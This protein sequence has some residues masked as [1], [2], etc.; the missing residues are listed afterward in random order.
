M[1]LRKE[2]AR[3]YGSVQQFADDIT[4]H[5]NGLPVT[6]TKGSWSYTARKFVARHRTGVAAAALVILALVGGIVATERQARIARNERAKAQKRFDDVRQF[7][8][9]LIF[10]IHDALQDIPGTT[11]ARNLLLDRAV[12]YLDRVAKDADGDSELQR[13]LAWGYQRLA[14]VQGDATVSNVG[15]ISAAEVSAKKATALFEA[16]AS[17]NPS[18]VPINS[19]SR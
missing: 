5:L 9:S 10:E 19:M 1:A 4:R 15:Q 16:V 7:S 18:N 12:Q 17:A 2:P 8:N 13:E 6:S 3:R 11:P 14:T